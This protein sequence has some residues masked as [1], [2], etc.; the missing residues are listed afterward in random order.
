MNFQKDNSFRLLAR[1][2][3]Q[4]GRSGQNL[5]NLCAYLNSSRCM[6]PRLNM[7]LHICS[8]SSV[9]IL[10]RL[11]SQQRL[12]NPWRWKRPAARIPCPSP[13]TSSKICL[14]ATL[15]STIT[16]LPIH[17]SYLF[18]EARNMFCFLYFIGVQQMTLCV[19]QPLETNQ[20][21]SF[22]TI[23]SSQSTL[24]W[25]GSCWLRPL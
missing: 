19:S 12:R 21:R 14:L 5:P 23:I 7:S 22:Q 4:W 11:S 17:L 20:E 16:C 13:I 2:M 8:S 9:L 1:L 25:S 18:T 3:L 15:L 6:P 10:I 24:Q